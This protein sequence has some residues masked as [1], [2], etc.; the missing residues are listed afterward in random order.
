M[1]KAKKKPKFIRELWN[2][3]A[4]KEEKVEAAIN[5]ID[6]LISDRVKLDSAGTVMDKLHEKTDKEY[7]VH[8]VRSI[9]G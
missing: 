8:Q 3:R 1:H 6:D 5:C 7:K 2:R 4:A 9:L